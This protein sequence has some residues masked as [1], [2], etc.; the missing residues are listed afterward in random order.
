MLTV[1]LSVAGLL[2]SLI[3]AS[4]LFLNFILSKKQNDTLEFENRRLQ[5]KEI[6]HSADEK[7]KMELR[8]EFMVKLEALEHQFAKVDEL[9]Q[10]I[11][12]KQHQSIEAI[13][14]LKIRL[15]KLE[16]SLPI[17][18]FAKKRGK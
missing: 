6:A 3:T 15:T 10:E 8:G 5:I 14:D 2:I 18:E 9:L 16:V 13:D 4:I 17:C 1:L 11:L 12:K 7:L